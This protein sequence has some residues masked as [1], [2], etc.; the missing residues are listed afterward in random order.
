MLRSTV[1]TGLLATVLCP[2][3]ASAR[4]PQ[5]VSEPPTVVLVHGAFADA[6]SWDE[7]AMRLRAHGV[8]VIAVDNPLTS[9]DADVQVTRRAIEAAPGKVVLVG[10]SWGGTVIIARGLQALQN[11]GGFLSLD[12]ATFRQDFAQDL[13]SSVARVLYQKQRPLKA[14]ALSEPVQNAA[15]RSHPSWY[16]LSRNDRMLSPQLQAATAER[17]GAELR[18]LGSSHVSP[19]SEPREV[20]DVILEAAGRRPAEDDSPRFTGG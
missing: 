18:S 3:I 8:L 13:R 7:V 1:L 2:F 19:V 17:I 10:H 5:P 11:H 14:S 20:S 12:E 16:V 6:S 15:W 4:T 9:L